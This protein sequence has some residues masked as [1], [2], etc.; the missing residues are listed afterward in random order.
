MHIFIDSELPSYATLKFVYDIGSRAPALY[1]FVASTPVQKLINRRGLVGPSKAFQ[2]LWQKNIYK[3]F[4]HD[5]MTD[6]KSRY[7]FL[8]YLLSILAVK[9]YFISVSKNTNLQFYFWLEQAFK[10][11]L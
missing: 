2:K 7:Q 6:T 8:F 5:W 4:A 9:R 3:S 1:F 10:I 11:S